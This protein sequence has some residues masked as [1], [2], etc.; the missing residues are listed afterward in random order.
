MI[1]ATVDQ[2][3]QLDCNIQFFPMSAA[4]D[5]EIMLFRPLTM[6]PKKNIIRDRVSYEISYKLQ[7]RVNPMAEAT[8][9]A[10]NE[11]GDLFE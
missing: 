5:A 8:Q 11:I 9:T 7:V 2:D 10:K 4:H 3:R 6:K 1:P